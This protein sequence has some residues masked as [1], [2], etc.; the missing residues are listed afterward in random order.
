[1]D[2]FDKLLPVVILG[3]LGTILL[4]LLRRKPTMEAP[5]P[6]VVVAVPSENLPAPVAVVNDA[7]EIVVAPNAAITRKRE[8]K[9]PTA[10]A[11][12]PSTIDTALGLLHDRQTLAATF[13]LREVLA[14]P[15]S[16][17]ARLPRNR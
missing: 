6:A 1:M 2:Q 15:V 14:P 5:K 11:S 7:C 12:P 9:P 13:V 3:V 10:P 17:Q 16:R 4:V 8:R